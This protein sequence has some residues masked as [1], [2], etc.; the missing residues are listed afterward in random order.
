MIF[1]NPLIRMSRVSTTLGLRN[2]NTHPVRGVIVICS[3][4]VLLGIFRLHIW[5]N[6]H[7]TDSIRTWIERFQSCSRSPGQYVSL[8]EID[9]QSVVW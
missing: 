2:D 1:Y 6:P 8:R 9:R 7:R 5:C 3:I 4:R